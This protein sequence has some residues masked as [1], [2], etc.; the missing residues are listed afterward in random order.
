MTTYCRAPINHVADGDPVPVETEIGDGRR[1]DLSWS[2]QGFELRSLP[3][4]VD[5]WDDPAEVEARHHPEIARFV[6]DEVG[7]DAVLFYPPI[8]RDPVGATRDRD[9][10]P[11][12]AAHSDYTE[13]YR[14]ML[15]TP[16]HPYLDILAPSMRRAGVTPTDLARASRILTLQFWR[17]TGPALPDRPLA[18]CDATTVDRDELVSHRVESYAGRP[19]RFQTFLLRPP[20]GADRRR[21]LTFPGL[22]VDEVVVFRS[23]D[24]DRVADGQP[25]WTPHSAFVD[26]TVGPGAPGRRSVEVRAI[27]VFD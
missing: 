17:N 7:C 26:P 3:S 19:T 16:D 24:S 2:V 9:L 12:E 22:T 25:F 4:A 20:T 27:C 1:A 23:F 13:D 10:A 18:L 15:A 5:R 21:W 14:P 8:G 11:I 6:T